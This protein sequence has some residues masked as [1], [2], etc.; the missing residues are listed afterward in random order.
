MK[1][2]LHEYNG[3]FSIEL[4]PEDQEDAVKLVRLA[5]NKTKKLRSV[6]VNAHRDNTI[7]STHKYKDK[8][9]VCFYCNR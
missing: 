6:S 2:T 9:D 5:I 3:C 4:K 1:V 7:T 8:E